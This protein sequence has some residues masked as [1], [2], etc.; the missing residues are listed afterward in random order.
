M[1][2]PHGVGAKPSR[3]EPAALLAALR[4][5]RS[6]TAHFVEMRYLHLLNQ[7]QQSSGRLLY[8]A[9]DYLQKTTTEPIRVTSDHQRRPLTIEQQGQPNRAIALQ[10]YSAIG[11]LVDSTGQPSPAIC[12]R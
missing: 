7:P 10:D 8:V 11:T 2:R 3:V 9:P 1:C 5:V 6:S 12:R 4:Q